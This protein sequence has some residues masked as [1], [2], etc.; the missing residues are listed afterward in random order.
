MIGLTRE[1]G[2]VT[3]THP[4][5]PPNPHSAAVRLA[6]TPGDMA[7]AVLVLLVPVAI[8]AAVYVFFLGGNNVI[9]I[10]PS[11]TYANARLSAGFTVLEPTGLSSG[12]KPVSSAYV[13]G[14]PS[15]LRVGY[16]AP[17]GDG[18]QLVESDVPTDTLLKKEIGGYDIVGRPSDTAGRTW[19]E[20]RSKS[21][22]NLALVYTDANTTVIIR[23]QSDATEL[24]DLAAA[25]K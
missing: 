13:A 14:K 23:G 20:V 15:T 22:G 19:S 5:A 10:D 21:G 7:K 18:L 24:T 8:L 25:L 9:A 2:W 1:D 6:R 3:T 11:N 17:N 4:A 12:W 16:I